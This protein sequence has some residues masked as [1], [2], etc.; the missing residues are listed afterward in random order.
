MKFSFS[1]SLRSLC[2]LYISKI[3]M[4]NQEKKL[5]GAGSSIRSPYLSSHLN[6]SCTNILTLLFSAS[7]FS[8]KLL[9]NIFII[10][11]I[12]LKSIIFDTVV[13]NI[14]HTYPKTV[15]YLKCWNS[16]CPYKVLNSEINPLYISEK[17]SLLS[18]KNTVNTWENKKVKQKQ[19]KRN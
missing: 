3:T 16:T 13:N 10:H 15:R 7:P 11:T 12:R 6:L 8:S 4:K 2:L 9:N 14:R 5:S 1:I 17:S 18:L 19:I